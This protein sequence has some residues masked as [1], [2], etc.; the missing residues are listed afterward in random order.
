M[1]NEISVFFNRQYFI[2][3]LMSDFDFWHLYRSNRY[4]KILSIVFLEKISF[5]AI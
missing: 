2:N 1:A 3:I 4:I 5:V